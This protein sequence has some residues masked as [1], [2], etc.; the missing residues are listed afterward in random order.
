MSKVTTLQLAAQVR[1]SNREADRRRHESRPRTQVRKGQ[2]YR[3]LQ[4]APGGLLDK[5]ADELLTT[6]DG[7]AIIKGLYPDKGF[8]DD[9]IPRA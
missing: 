6:A 4:E 3:L 7:L 1:L 5:L 9:G 2:I 8:T